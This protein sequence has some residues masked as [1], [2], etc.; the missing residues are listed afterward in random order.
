[1]RLRDGS[2]DDVL[3]ELALLLDQQHTRAA[4]RVKRLCAQQYRTLRAYY[5]HLLRA[6]NKGR[7]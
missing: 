2:I 3:A 7:R 1:M 4:R 6:L 5:L